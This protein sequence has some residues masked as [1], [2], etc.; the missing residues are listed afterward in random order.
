MRLSCAV[1]LFV[2]GCWNLFEVE[3]A[4]DPTP[5]ASAE[6]ITAELLGEWSGCMSAENF[7]VS[8]M[9]TSWPGVVVLTTNKSC[10]DCHATGQ[11]GFIATNDANLFFNLITTQ[12]SFLQQY[13]AVDLPDARMIVNAQNFIAMGNADPPNTDHPKFDGAANPGLTSLEQ[14]YD[15]T[16]QRKADHA[17]DPSRLTN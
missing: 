11:F 5:D 2:T 12:R 1:L 6:V 10:G 17:C 15:L 3:P 4:A 14:F 7:Q 16:A 13:F 8:A 9:A